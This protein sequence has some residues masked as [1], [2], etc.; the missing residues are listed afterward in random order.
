M[1]IKT[2][3]GLL[4]GCL[5]RRNLTMKL[6]AAC[7][8]AAL[9]S[10]PPFT[11]AQT[12]TATSSALPRL[13]R[14]GGTVKDLNGN[15][16]AGV[17]GVTFA[18]YSEQ[19]D[20]PALW[21]ETQN[22][23]ADKNGRYLAL[24]GST[25]PEGLPTEMF[26]SG[27]ARWVGVQISG[28]AEQPRVLLVSAPYALKAGDAETIGGLPPSAFVL[29]SGS[30]G[31]A[32]GGK[33]AG[34]SAADAHKNSSPPPS[35]PDITGKGT[36]D[37]I[38]M[39]D[40]TS[41]IID[42]IIFQKSSEIGIAT[43]TPAATLDV[44]GKTDIRDTLTLYPKSTD[45]TLAVNGTSFKISSTGKVTFISGQTFP[46]AGTIT[47]ITTASGSGLSGGGTT[48]TL[49]LAVP[50]AGITNT[51]LANSKVTLNAS[52][53]GGLTV[54]GAM[55]LGDTY[56][57][58]LKTCTANQVLQYIGTAWACS[59]A[60][61]GTITG[62]TAGT[63]MTGGGTS[64]TV[65]LNNTG[66]LG[67]T[68]GTGIS[69]TGG[70]TPTLSVS[71]V[72]LLAASNTFTGSNNFVVSAYSAI[73]ATSSS[74]GFNGLAA[75][76]NATSGGSNGVYATTQ[77][78]SGAGVVGSNLSYGAGVNGLSGTS[79]TGCLECVNYSYGVN[80]QSTYGYGVVGTVG[81]SGVDGVH[82]ES[83]S[84]NSGVAGLNFN[85]TSGY[86]V[87]GN[88][89]S[90]G[91]TGVVGLNFSS[92]SGIGGGFYSYSNDGDAL[93]AYSQ[94]GGYAAF[95]EGNVDV[96][97]NLSKAGGSFKIDHP[98][99]PA[100]KYLY[101][102]FVESPDMKNIYDGLATL[103]ANGEAAIQ[104]PDWFGVLNRE[105]RYQLTCIG[106][107]A[108][109]YIAEEL[110][111]NQF[112]IG[113]GRAGMRV[114]WQITGIRQ[115]P[116]ANAHRIPVE[117]EKDEKLKGFYLHPELYGAPAEKQIEW[118][119]HPGM[120]KK[121]QQTTQQMKEKQARLTESAA[122]PHGSPK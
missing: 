100:N 27:Q 110:A 42:S 16:L 113:G 120:M 7:V 50:S 53:A 33:G 35:N 70:Q 6:R 45:S 103:D 23:T 117:E 96:D 18:L 98:L 25:A 55:T 36:V 28:Q 76:E 101:H 69:S 39:W 48:G 31:T 24:L 57:I 77:D 43:T 49:S 81:S 118:A 14:F 79:F 13:V 88:S 26:T 66:L 1:K 80:G 97:G 41:D 104:M 34:A 65:T 46:G 67:L 75:A 99:D 83:S 91:G 78:S 86:G 84:E 5:I 115:D 19:T 37:Y 47:G 105:F 62:V 72:P 61:T 21:I 108:P 8:V 11:S 32:N 111:N 22:V 93:F 64:G 51:M 74:P 94:S 87:Y 114:S 107:F 68:A 10:L 44:N 92:S 30:Q 9:L 121:L 40:T 15:P 106:G 4:A 116:W 59:N 58:G 109:V 38:P 85:T 102:S 52:A 119:R 54:P 122:L 73:G 2:K 82:G 89:Q 90:P 20:G 60:G 56:T 63:G 29:A 95:L 3:F 71:G 12:P 112:K 17:V